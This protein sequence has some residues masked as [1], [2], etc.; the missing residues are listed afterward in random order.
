[1]PGG[2]VSQNIASQIEYI[3]GTLEE[4]V[5]LQGVLRKRIAK[6]TDIKAISN[7]PARI[8]FNVLTG[9]I[10]R[11]GANLFDGQ[12]MGR[13]SAPTQAFG[14]LSAVPFVQASEYTSL[15]EFS[16]ESDEKA[17]ENYVTLTNRQ[18]TE[19]YA[20]YMDSL[21]ANSSG[22]NDL[23]TVVSVSGNE[24]VVNNADIFQ[25]NQIVDVW[26]AIGGTLRGSWQIQSID[27]SNTALWGT[28]APPA[29]TTT[30]DVLM[31]TGSSGQQNSGIFGILNY[32]VGTNTGNFMGIPRSAFPGKFNTRFVYPGG[33][34]ATGP[35]TPANVR[36]ML[37]QMKL[38][39]GADTDEA[40]FVVH[41][42]VDVQASWENNAIPVQT[43]FYNEMKG[44]NSADMLKKNMPTAIAGR[45]FLL[46]VRAK[47]GRIDGLNLAHW[48]R[49]E[50]KALDLHEVGGQTLF[51]IYGA[52]GGLNSS[53]IF[54]YEGMEQLGLGQPLRDCY[55]PSI[56]IPKNYFG[57]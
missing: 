6:A 51:P 57:H 11:T 49:L 47:P 56:T 22:A 21:Y 38:A 27:P 37:N 24:V 28:T 53:Q 50:T 12:D 15:S 26:S 33:A 4:L 40:K 2:S 54:Y 35:L 45:E 30:G 17:I 13:G 31:V 19:T 14:N 42:N 39:M 5:L 41:G 18:A 32:H 9:A 23:D 7:R 44:D 16:T 34:A 36:A 55:M 3:R 25:D 46:N 1:M 29:G 43:I 48:F 52:S 8:P 20:G 10:F